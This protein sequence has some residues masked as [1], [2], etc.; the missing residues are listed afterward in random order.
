MK[1][2]LPILIIAL[3]CIA[4]NH[5][6]QTPSVLDIISNV[7]YGDTHACSSWAN[8]YWEVF[9]HRGEMEFTALTK[10]ITPTTF[11]SIRHVIEKEF[12][13][14]EYDKTNFP[15]DQITEDGFYWH[16]SKTCCDEVYYWSND[17]LAIAWSLFEA[18]ESIGH[19]YLDI[20]RF[21][22]KWVS[23]LENKNP[24]KDSTKYI[25]VYFR[26]DTIINDFEVSG[27]LYPAY[28]EKTGWDEWTNGAR[29]FFR[30]RKTGHEYV[31][32]DWSEKWHCFK[33]MFMSKNVHDIVNSEGFTG[34]KNGDTYIFAYDTTPSIM[35][36]SPLF[37][38]AEY[39]FYDA[40]FDGEDELLFNYYR[41]G[42]KGCLMCEIYEITDT[43]LVLKYPM[44]YNGWFTIDENT[45][46]YP[47]KKMI[48]KYSESGMFYWTDFYFGVDDDAN[49]HFL[50][51]VEHNLNS[52]NDSIL[53][54]TIY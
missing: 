52:T 31:W 46:F 23:D 38:N 24:F 9:G 45:V 8:R 7:R 12:G 11:D 26:F 37:A 43:A 49:Y 36:E 34:F 28:A 19:A 42:P 35:P 2:F 29:V 25:S 50:Y 44:E 3:S 53:T 41:G 17:S 18:E 15:K 5:T 6:R 16:L 40:D 54:D 47:E 39:M 32:T 51:Y 22:W 27:I 20:K 13:P 4:C 14:Y 10:S 1:R 33:Q 48:C 30:S 21:S